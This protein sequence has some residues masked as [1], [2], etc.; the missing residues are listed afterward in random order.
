MKFL[1][2]FMVGK[3]SDG[4]REGFHDDNSRMRELNNQDRKKTEEEIECHVCS[5]FWN[6]TKFINVCGVCLV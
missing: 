2:N 6:G 5:R 3:F 1:T 4:I